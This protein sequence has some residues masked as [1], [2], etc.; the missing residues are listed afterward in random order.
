MVI[1]MR[2]LNRWTKFENKVML[3]NLEKPIDML[4]KLIPSKSRKQ[5]LSK[6]RYLGYNYRLM[7]SRRNAGRTLSLT[8]TEKAYI[9]GIIDGEGTIG[10]HADKRRN[11]GLLYQPRVSIA[12]CDRSL[13]EWVENKLC[14][15]HIHRVEFEVNNYDVI[16]LLKAIRPYLRVKKKQADSMLEFVDLRLSRN[17]WQNPHTKRELETV[18]EVHQ[19]NIKPQLRKRI[20]SERE[21][22][23]YLAKHSIKTITLGGE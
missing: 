3:S 9:A 2:T 23:E 10:F 19:L 14:F 8:E 18:Q 12:N 13:L 6:I 17:Q 20:P 22:T 16:P 1:D 15:G 7:E 11:N 21:V 5:I 4:E